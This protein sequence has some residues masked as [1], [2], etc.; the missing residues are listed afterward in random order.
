MTQTSS[1]KKRAKTGIANIEFSDGTKI[2]IPEGRSGNYTRKGSLQGIQKIP[3]EKQITELPGEQIEG[4]DEYD[5]LEYPPPS[6]NPQ[7]RKIWATGIANITRR[8]N[9]D[10]S[11]LSLFE[12]YCSLLVTLR[13]LDE[14]I[15]KNGQ[16]YRVVTLTG[17]SRRT[18]PE[19]LERGKTIT[20]IAQYAKILDLLPKKDKS[21]TVKKADEVDWT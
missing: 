8:E 14:F 5:K 10:A 11:H 3:E 1:R 7:F 4:T 15:L 9:F 21:K 19:V 2:P 13:T 20:Q 18:H 16:T 6:K 12:T 17:D